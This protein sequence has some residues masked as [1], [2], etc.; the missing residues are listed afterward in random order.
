MIQPQFGD[1]QEAVAQVNITVANRIFQQML[2]HPLLEKICREEGRMGGYFCDG[3]ND[4][5]DPANRLVAQVGDPN[6]E[7]AQKYFDYCVEKECRLGQHP[8]DLLSRD[9][10]VPEEG[11]WGGAVRG[12]KRRGSL[13]CLPEQADEIFGYAYLVAIG[14][15]EVPEVLDRLERSPNDFETVFYDLELKDLFKA[16]C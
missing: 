15:L 1:Y 5:E 13:S 10:R 8:E 2:K 7:K 3:P 4:N 6:Q 16:P 9:S 14:D 11:K 12:N